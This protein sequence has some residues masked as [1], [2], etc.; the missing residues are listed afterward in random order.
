MLKKIFFIIIFSMLFTIA[1][2]AQTSYTLKCK[3]QLLDKS[4]ELLMSQIGITEKTGHNDGKEIEK[5][6]PPVGLDPNNKYPYCAAGQVW[7]F[8]QSCIYLK[9]PFS[10]IPIARTGLANGI[11]NAAMRTGVKT[12]FIAL[13][14]GLLVWRMPRDNTG[15]IERIIETKQAGWV[16]TVGFNTTSGAGNQ[17]EGGGVHKRN[18]NTKSLLGRMRVRG[19]INFQAV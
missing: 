14:D 18:R 2:S 13:R 19:I 4:R 8:W 3:K 10:E 15:H 17:S 16:V 7:V 9:L 1:A 6:Y 11:F 12:K 5:Y